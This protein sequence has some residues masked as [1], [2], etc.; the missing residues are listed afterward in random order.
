MYSCKKI[1]VSL[2]IVLGFMVQSLPAAALDLYG[3]GSYWGGKDDADDS[4]GAG[5]GISQSIIIDTLTL[6]ARV[7]FFEASDLEDGDSLSLVPIDLGLQLHII[8]GSPAI[9]PYGLAGISFVWADADELDVDSTV[10][11]YAG[12]GV[13]FQVA[14]SVKIFGEALYRYTEVN[15]DSDLGDLDASG[16][17]ING[18]I[19]FSLF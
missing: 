1:M 7:Y 3:F 18:G 17:N 6:D 16:F 2:A 10:G 15:S 11:A 12:A 4:M 19:K 5:L 14:P 8:P 13:N 9:D